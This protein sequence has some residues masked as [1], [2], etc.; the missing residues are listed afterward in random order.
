MNVKNQM[1]CEVNEAFAKE[2]QNTPQ[3]TGDTQKSCVFFQYG[4]PIQS[5][6]VL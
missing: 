6:S 5:N 2:F 3:K 4:F 1:S